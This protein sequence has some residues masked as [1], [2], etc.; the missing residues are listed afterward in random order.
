M[1]VAVVDRVILFLIQARHLPSPI[2]DTLGCK[3]YSLEYNLK[4]V[5]QT[6]QYYK[7]NQETDPLNKL[8][9]EDEN[10][11]TN[12]QQDDQQSATLDEK[13]YSQLEERSDAI[14]KHKINQFEDKK[15]E[16]R[17]VTETK[18]SGS[19]IF[20]DIT[21]DDSYKFEKG[22]KCLSQFPEWDLNIMQLGSCDVE[23]IQSGKWRTVSSDTKLG[24]SK[25]R[26]Q[27]VLRNKV[28]CDIRNYFSKNQFMVLDS[29]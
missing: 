29:Q 9:G 14:R 23:A 28:N 21:D 26:A 22:L 7:Q 17:K 24:I 25:F 15:I 11:D 20:Q 16:E 4:L 13:N 18:S 19:Q 27:E 10:Q 3:L 5:L 12:N 6:Q 2:L 8:S 1:S